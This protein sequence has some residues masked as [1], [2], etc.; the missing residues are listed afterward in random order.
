MKTI[1]TTLIVLLLMVANCAMA[2]AASFTLTAKVTDE[3]NLPIENVEAMLVNP[4]T[5]QVIQAKA[6]TVKGE[7]VFDGLC[8]GKYILTVSTTDKKNLET[9]KVEMNGKTLEKE[10]KMIPID[11][12]AVVAL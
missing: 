10:I 9:Q 1:T 2:S 5:R 7:F 11:E 3:N 6:S 8:C 12:L 4:E